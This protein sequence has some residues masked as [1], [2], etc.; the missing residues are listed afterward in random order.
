MINRSCGCGK[1]S[2][3]RVKTPTRRDV[4]FCCYL[5]HQSHGMVCASASGEKVHKRMYACG[6]LVFLTV[7]LFYSKDLFCGRV[8]FY[9]AIKVQKQ[10]L[11]WQC[12]LQYCV[13][14][15]WSFCPPSFASVCW[16]YLC[17][18]VYVTDV[19][20]LTFSSS[21][22]LL[23]CRTMPQTLLCYCDFLFGE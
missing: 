6:S 9:R 11:P 20:G 13:R 15:Y 2:G 22:F 23:H 1:T 14:Y 16:L 8:M 5:L 4:D 19:C 10:F 18:V 12:L 3:N 7:V 17:C 21:F